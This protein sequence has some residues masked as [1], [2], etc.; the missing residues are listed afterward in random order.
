M[1]SSSTRVRCSDKYEAQKLAGLVYVRD[2]GETN[3]SAILNIIG[4]EVVLGLRDGSAHS[5]T[6]Y[7]A[8]NVEAFADFCQSVFDGEHRLAGAEAAGSLVEISKA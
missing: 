1:A 3:I 8:E 4:S 5:V 2:S 7:D 6:L